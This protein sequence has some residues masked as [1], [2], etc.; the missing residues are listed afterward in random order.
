M[1]KTNRGKK[2]DKMRPWLWF[3]GFL[4][5]VIIAAAIIVLLPAPDPLAG[6]DTVA[7]RVGDEPAA[8]QGIDFEDELRVV[9]GDRDI[10]IVSDESAADAVLS[11]EDF[12][13]NLG[14][15]QISLTDG[16]LSGRAS[17]VCRVANVATGETHVLDFYLKI[18]NGTVS[19]ELVPRKFWQ[20]WK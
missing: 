7:V 12:S 2:K 16:R 10:R 5:L 14:D 9:L 8:P 3:G 6:V 20:F 13:F 4:W 1:T 11:L 19:A 15:I 18:E 17:A